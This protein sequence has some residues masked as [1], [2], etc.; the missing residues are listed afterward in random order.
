VYKLAAGKTRYYSLFTSLRKP[1]GSLTIDIE[2]T[3]KLMLEHFT[4]EDNVKDDNEFHKQNRAQSQ[5]TVN[6]P[7]Y[8][9]FTLVEIRNAVESMNNKK[10]PGEDNITGK[11]FKQAFETFPK[12]ITAMYNGCLR[13][14]IFSKRRKRA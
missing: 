1:D 11:I 2:E 7:D 5:G 10:V 3:V 9:K 12:Y 14:G 8:R 6:T 4:P 13:N